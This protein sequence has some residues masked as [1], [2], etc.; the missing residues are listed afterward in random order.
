MELLRATF[1]SIEGLPDAT[2]S[3]ADSAGR[4]N[5]VTLVTG[6]AASGKTRV[7][8]A[9]I[10]AKEVIAPY[11]LPV[12]AQSWVRRGTDAAKVELTFQLTE[13]EQKLCGGI[14]PVVEAEALFN[15]SRC[16]A[17]VDA[18]FVSLLERY[19]HDA[20][21]PKL[22]Y[23]P[24]SRALPPAGA[25]QGLGAFEQRIWRLKTESRKFGFVPRLLLSLATDAG[26]RA[27][28]ESVLA[29]L[30]STVRY[31]AP[32]GDDLLS[33]FSSSGSDPRSIDALSSSEVDAIV[34]AAT[35]TM[36]RHDNSIVLVDRPESA[37]DEASL[38]SWLEGLR[39]L[40]PGVQL[41][42]AS[43][44]PALRACVPPAA[45]ISLSIGA[46]P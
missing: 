20:R 5:P 29:G 43:G 21:Y 31:R 22:D 36:V 40:A 19:E 2:I 13:N 14:E 6:P 10:A 41:I 17:E 33:C 4:A 9:L 12:T 35:A 1:L 38:P 27:R 16:S 39:G 37:V 42:V 30:S 3:F 24:A 26:A 34:F 28:F 45:T 23:F 18:G 44:S 11:G 15:T 7:L 25:A 8:S 32:R 46:R